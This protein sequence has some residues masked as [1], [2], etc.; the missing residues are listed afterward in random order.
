MPRRSMVRKI[1]AFQQLTD[2]ERDDVVA[3]CCG[4]QAIS[5]RR[6]I[7][8][9]G[10]KPTHVRVV[11]EGW[12]ARYALT[13][14]GARRITAFLLPGDFCD[15]H[16]TSLNVMDHGIVALTDCRVG[17]IEKTAIDQITRS[18][19][20]LTLAFWRATLVDEAILR[21]WIVN[22]GRKNATQHIAHLFC[23]LQARLSLIGMAGE[24]DIIVPL[25]QEEVADA[26]G[27]TNVHVNRTLRD[28][29]E[30]GLIEIT[31]SAVHIPNI[32]A[33]RREA[34]FDPTYLHLRDEGP[35]EQRAWR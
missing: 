9:A 16:I 29:R 4:V 18:T 8:S 17:L 35:T 32:A 19:P 2:A 3:L 24:N 13:D 7:V 30:R 31:G 25:T 15:I 33:L 23:E 11:L 20:A 14:S 10:D 34:E 1:E 27:L 26:A 21:Q 6:D 12:A 22:A 5:R 28:L